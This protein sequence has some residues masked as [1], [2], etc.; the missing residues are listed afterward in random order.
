MTRIIFAVV[1]AAVMVLLTDSAKATSVKK[2]DT[3]YIQYVASGFSRTLVS[4]W[5]PALAV[6]IY[7]T[8]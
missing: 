8:G 3:T 7:L 5:R 2:P 4:T 1:I 6:T